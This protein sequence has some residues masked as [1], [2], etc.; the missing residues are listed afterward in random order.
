VFEHSPLTDDVAY[1]L[2]AYDCHTTSARPEGVEVRARFTFILADILERKL[3]AIVL[4]LH[5]AHLAKC[6]LAHHSQQSEVVEVD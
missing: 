3:V 6:A 5:Y 2:G 4:A 1:T